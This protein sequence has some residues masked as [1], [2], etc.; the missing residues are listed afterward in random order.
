M[1]T[2]MDY[3][4]L[5]HIHRRETY[6]DDDR[7]TAVYPGSPEGLDPSETGTRYASLVELD[8]T[9]ASVS[10]LP[11][12]GREVRR[13]RMDVTDYDSAEVAAV[14]QESRGDNVLLTAR[15]VGRPRNLLDVEQIRERLAPDFFWLTLED[16]TEMAFSEVV[17]K[18]ALEGTVAGR[19]V[20]SLRQR[21]LASE[22]EPERSALNLAL[23]LGL[24]S[25]QQRSI[26]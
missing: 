1:S 15:L 11:V 9:G 23:K 13:V 24:A 22:D 21:I 8:G 25:L 4:A 16:E 26:L 17:E 3:V 5:G 14:L 12:N 10:F 18:L 2:G 6:A 7:I 20:R 19:L